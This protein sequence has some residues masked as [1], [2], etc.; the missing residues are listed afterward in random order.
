MKI[1]SVLHFPVFG[2]PHN[3]NAKVGALL[4]GE[5]VD[6]TLLLPETAVDAARRVEA[7]G[8]KTH[9]MPLARL[10]K[11][12]NPAEHIRYIRSFRHNVR[13]IR[14]I[15]REKEIDVV[16]VNGL[17]NPHAAIAAK[18][19]HVP[20][21]WQILDSV[22]PAK[23]R[24]LMRPLLMRYA[25]VIMCTGRKVAVDHLG[26]ALS[27]KPLILFH[28]PVDLKRF[29]PRPE[30]RA[31]ARAE[32]GLGESDLVV[33]NIANVNPMKGHLTFVRA[34]AA[35]RKVDP[36]LRFVIF[37]QTYDNHRP[38][39][40]RLLAQAAGLGLELGKD[41]QIVD[42]GTRVA[43]LAQAL[44]IY[45]LTSEPRSEGIS[46]AAEEA[47]A[48][49][50]PVISTETGS[51]SEIVLDGES[52]FMVAPHDIEAISRHTV[53]LA[54]DE[55]LRQRLGNGARAFALKH[56]AM[57]QCAALHLDAYRTALRHSRAVQ[58]LQTSP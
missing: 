6:S 15:I 19:E 7:A 2:G 45:W 16:V 41:L 20:V 32:L 24:R 31:A 48:L 28:P 27:H 23:V 43:E 34:A 38:Y 42:P 47:M 29:E 33:G 17:M 52:G 51:M 9:T 55:A 37:G 35:A 5:G 25:T 3:R 12:L 1:L 50:L 4:R 13:D 46:T 10:R 56:F 21:V 18:R 22:P 36:R 14:K 26:E 54:A 39:T 11:S 58:G 30:T 53:A 57:E 40:E 49:G 8:C 44:D